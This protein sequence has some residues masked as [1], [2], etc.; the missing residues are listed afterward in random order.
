MTPAAERSLLPAERE[1]DADEELHS[2]EIG[3]HALACD[4]VHRR[5]ARRSNRRARKCSVELAQ[6]LKLVSKSSM[7]Q[8]AAGVLVLVA[9]ECPAN[10]PIPRPVAGHV[11]IVGRGCVVSKD[12]IP[13][14]GA[15]PHTEI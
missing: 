5:Q 4:E 7:Q 14:G 1:T 3:V 10:D 2:A 6:V 13:R 12:E 15:E 8:K 11:E 9:E